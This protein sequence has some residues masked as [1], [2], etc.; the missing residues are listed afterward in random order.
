MIDPTHDAILEAFELALDTQLRA[1]R[2][3]RGR[4]RAS[5]PKAGKGLSNVNM[6]FEILRRA[7]TPMHVDD[8]IV[9]LARSYGVQPAR[10]S[11]VSALS[12][13]VAAGDRFEKSAPNTFGLRADAL[14]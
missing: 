10:D 13:K 8:L 3:L 9:E 5:V 6:S 1:V 7:K 11:L 12:K 4:R 2:K 14:G